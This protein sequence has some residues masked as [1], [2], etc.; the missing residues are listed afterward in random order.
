MKLEVYDVDTY[1]IPN[2]TLFLVK[3]ISW[4]HEYENTKFAY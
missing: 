4:I 2:F 3:M 1:H